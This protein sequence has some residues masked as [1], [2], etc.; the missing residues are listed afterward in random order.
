VIAIFLGDFSIIISIMYPLHCVTAP[1]KDVADKEILPLPVPG[2][3]PV[4]DSLPWVLSLWPA[5]LR[6]DRGGVVPVP[7]GTGS[8]RAGA[9][10][11]LHCTA[12]HAAELPWPPAVVVAAFRHK[13]TRDSA[14]PSASP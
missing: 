9:L 1:H 6:E 3:L 13:D 7:Q 2:G 14:V 8:F 11:S 4:P 10:H 12:L 5:A